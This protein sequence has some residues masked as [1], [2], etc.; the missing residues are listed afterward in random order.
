MRE[1]EF[2]GKRID[3]GLWVYG[4]LILCGVSGKAYILPS[5]SEVN[6]SKKVNHEGCLFLVT[7][8]VEEETICQYTGLL[9]K[10]DKKIYEGDIV[11]LFQLD[12][13]H[14]SDYDFVGVVTYMPNNDSW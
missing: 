7:C 6:E 4:S 1:I 9:D 3:N 5:G 8:E 14:N 10:N 13:G 2:R 11:K 12:G